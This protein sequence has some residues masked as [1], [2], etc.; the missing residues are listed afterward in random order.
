[1]A[2]ALLQRRYYVNE[3]TRLVGVAPRVITQYYVT[4]QQQKETFFEM[5][6]SLM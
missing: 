6:C 5:H 3:A 2:V 4:Y 1:M